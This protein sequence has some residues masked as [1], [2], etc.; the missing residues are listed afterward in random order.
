MASNVKELSEVARDLKGLLPEAIEPGAGASSPLVQQIRDA[1]LTI[2]DAN[3][4][5][6]SEIYISVL[7][8][9]ILTNKVNLPA[10]LN[11]LPKLKL[12]QHDIRPILAMLNEDFIIEHGKEITAH[13]LM[14]S[15]R[16]WSDQEKRD[17]LGTANELLASIQKKFPD[18]VFGYGFAL[19]VTRS[20]DFMPHD[21]DIDI[22]VAADGSTTKTITDA[23]LELSLHLQEEGWAV[24]GNWAGHRKVAR[25]GASV[26]VDVFVGLREGEFVSFIP[27]PRKK[28]RYDEVFPGR[29][30]KVK[31][32]ECL[33]PADPERYLAVVYGEDWRTPKPNWHH[34]WSIKDYN[35]ILRQTL[36]PYSFHASSLIERGINWVVVDKN[37]TPTAVHSTE[38]ADA[39][40]SLDLR[41][42]SMQE[43]L[44]GL[45]DC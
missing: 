9:F 31:D 3:E 35:A 44:L 33:F 16:F 37:G 19:S 1:A 10:V 22:I 4:R 42:L 29:K 23:L 11:R 41:W 15:F 24:Y 17:Y 36:S 13:G 39:K 14:R 25:R 18:S 6:L 40:S 8:E 45:A 32:V 5:A 21:D 12:T 26:D 43:R 28:L 20:S 30:E 38:P 7:E 2:S 27:G 34:N